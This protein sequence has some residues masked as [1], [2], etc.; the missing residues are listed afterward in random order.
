MPAVP[1]EVTF[2][3]RAPLY[4]W[5]GTWRGRGGTIFD[6]VQQG[7]RF[8]V[9]GPLANAR[10]QLGGSR[11]QGT[12]THA[13]MPGMIGTFDMVLSNDGRYARG[14]VRWAG[15]PLEDLWTRISESPQ[16]LAEDIAQTEGVKPG[17]L[18]RTVPAQSQP[19][20]LEYDENA[21]HTVTPAAGNAVTIEQ[22]QTWTHDNA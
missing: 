15:I 11:A 7:N 5:T 3:D 2:V 10:A 4:S 16:P 9:S 6:I 21:N 1:P 19:V 13:N 8:S 14:T 20:I 17:D 18:S 12:M 22:F